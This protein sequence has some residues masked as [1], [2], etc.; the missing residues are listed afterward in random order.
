M[1]ERYKISENELAELKKARKENINKRAEQRLLAVIMRAEGKSR[2]ETA[3]RTS[4]AVAYISELVGKYRDGGLSAIAE[5]HYGS[6]RWNMSFE[7]EEAFLEPFIRRAEKGEIVGAKE[8]KLAYEKQLGRELKS[9]GHIYRLLKRHGWR[10]VMPRPKHPQQAS[11]EEQNLAKNKIL[12]DRGV[13]RVE[14]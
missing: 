6:N 9:K 14:A 11:E 2:E 5:N 8:I 10:K 4:F 1:R 7:E 3:Q 12:R 13:Q